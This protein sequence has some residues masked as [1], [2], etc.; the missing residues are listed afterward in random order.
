MIF[1]YLFNQLGNMFKALLEQYRNLND[2]AFFSKLPHFFNSLTGI[3][4]IYYDILLMTI[5]LAISVLS[6]I[7]ATALCCVLFIHF[8]YCLKSG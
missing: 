7:F 4:I 5:P 8:I 3:Y 2:Y 6:P 1:P